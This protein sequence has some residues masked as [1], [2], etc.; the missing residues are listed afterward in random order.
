MRIFIKNYSLSDLYNKINS[1][2]KYLIKAEICCE[3]FTETCEYLISNN[4][5]Y[6]IINVDNEIKNYDNYYNELNL[7]VD[8]SIKI[9]Q[10]TCQLIPNHYAIP[11]NF[12]TFS[13]YK[14]S[15]IKFIV[16]ASDRTCFGI[17]LYDLDGIVP[18]D[19]YL[20][21]SEELDINNPLIKEEINEFLSMLN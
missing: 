2:K 1:L 21:I 16:K 15:K 10:P 19:F 4:D 14:N 5:L 11:F 9:K 7:T 3:V 12:L 13:L 20:E 18:L 17:D 8:Y 6:K